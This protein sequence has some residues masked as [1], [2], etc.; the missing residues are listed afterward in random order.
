MTALSQ[1]KTRLSF[2]T[3]DVVRYRGQLRPV[4]V[5][6]NEFTA[7]LRLKGTRQRF[8]LS[9][10]GMWNQAVKVAVEKKRAE[11][12]SKTHGSV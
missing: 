12:R 8:E 11:K 7:F 10:A 3:S 5:E 2:E 6:A 4:I 9:Y 1:R